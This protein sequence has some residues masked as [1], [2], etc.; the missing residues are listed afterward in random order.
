MA[1][2]VLSGL[3]YGYSLVPFYAIIYGLESQENLT[4][5]LLVYKTSATFWVRICELLSGYILIRGILRIRNYFK[6]Q[7][8][9]DF[10]DTKMLLRHALSFS[11]YL[12]GTSCTAISL[13]FY[14]IYSGSNIKGANAQQ[15]SAN[16]FYVLFTLDF[17]F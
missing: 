13:V 15:A 9:D 3:A 5:F 2:N 14:T 12:I 8:A 1:S 4:S 16:T 17:L 7:D 11:L 10:I 6:E